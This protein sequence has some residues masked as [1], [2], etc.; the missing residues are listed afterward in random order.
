MTNR[1]TPEMVI[2]AMRM[3]KNLPDL[4]HKDIV[5]ACIGTDRCTGDSFGPI[6][7]TAL[8]DQGYHVVGTL[9]FPLHAKNFNERV[10]EIPSDKYVIAIDACLGEASSVGEVKARRGS[11]SPGECVGRQLKE[12]GE[13]SIIGV[14]G[15]KTDSA[16]INHLI[17]SD[18]RLYDVLAMARTVINAIVEKYPIKERVEC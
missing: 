3:L 18:V 16:N 6:I 7:G 14:V 17:I 10:I 11:I 4:S 1:N 12:I 13:S 2:E 9:E 8:E 15:V 5:F